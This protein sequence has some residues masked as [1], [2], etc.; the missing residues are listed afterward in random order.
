M[1]DTSSI[2]GLPLIQPSQAQK[3]VTH[4]EALRILDALVQMAVEQINVTAPPTGPDAGAR[5]IVGAGATSAWAGRDGDVAVWEGS[6]WSFYTPSEGWVAYVIAD[7]TQAVFSG[8]A[9]T[10]NAAVGSSDQLGINASADTV[11]R[12]VVASQATLLTHD[13]A[14][15]RL[16]V[17]KAA[18]GDTASL[19]FQTD[20][21]GRAE[22]GL[23]GEDDFSI[24]VSADGAAWTTALRFDGATGAV[25]GQAVQQGPSDSAAGRL[26]LAEHG[27]LR[28]QMLGPVSQ[29]GGV[30]TGSVIE[31]GTTGQGDYVKWADGTMMCFRDVTID[32]NSVARQD[33][34]FAQPL[35]TP[36]GASVCGANVAEMDGTLRP[37]GAKRRRALGE[38]SVWTD[39]AGWRVQLHQA[40]EVDTVDIRLSAFGL[41]L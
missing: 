32:I 36:L 21:D 19:L 23:A 6:A 12:L 13:G 17:N 2:L 8:G 38:L 10:M 5:Y 31:R 26:M 37:G 20:F 39:T 7:Q 24:K 40:V 22:M 27:L 18:A 34:D 30:A 3:H 29:S 35:V 41:W 28:S 25:S 14:G 33:F 1:T 16:T 15:H 9:W 4:N 11:N